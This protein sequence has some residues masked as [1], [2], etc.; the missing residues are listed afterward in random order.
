MAKL[1]IKGHPARGKEVI[2][3]LEMLGGVNVF[4]LDGT[5]NNYYYYIDENSN[6]IYH[7]L[8]INLEYGIVYTLEEFEEKFPYKVDDVVVNHK[9]GKG[10]IIRML[11]IDNE[12]VYEIHFEGCMAYCKANELC[13]YDAFKGL[14]LQELTEYLSHATREELD[15]TME[16]IEI[17][18]APFKVG[19]KVIVKGYEKMGE[20]EIICVFKTYDGDIKYKT[21]NHLDTHYFMGD[22]L[23]KVEKSNKEENMEK[24]LEPVYELGTG[25]I[26]Y[27][28]EK[29][30]GEKYIPIGETTLY[31]QDGY[32]F[33]DETNNI[34]N[35]KKIT[36]ARK[37]PQYPKN[38][39]ELIKPKFKDGDIISNGRF[40]AIFHK[41][42][43]GH[44]YYHCWY[45]L[46]YNEF[47][48]KIDCGIGFIEEYRYA[49]EE[50]K[51]RL[52]DA[53]KAS[54]Y[55]WNPKTKAMERS[56]EK[57]G[58]TLNEYQRKALRTNAKSSD[59]E[60]Y[61]LFGL[62]AEVGE[63]ADKIAKAV[64]KEIITI[65]GDFIYEGK[66]AT[67][68]GLS[69]LEYA[70]FENGLKAELGDVLWF[71]AHLA[72][73]FSWTLEEVGQDNIDKLTSRQKR[74]VIIGNGDNR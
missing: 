50:E 73:R 20:D 17:A 9:Y 35:A 13:K 31:I 49:T 1:A 23:M 26:L 44:I 43:E 37:Q 74:G 28:E 52:F 66:N 53:I 34:I 40:I 58:L 38:Y 32:E 3:L 54:G 41:F 11:W 24:R 71:V 6:K 51:Q 68:D 15:K 16:E 39:E 7:C 62:F 25:K 5:M 22:S 48:A 33:R 12:I 70:E 72:H 18:L 8:S 64:R 56:A 63:I 60:S 19:D 2:Q 14:L 57:D 29:G 45:N 61:S 27:Y 21:K 65:N 36:L 55:K 4:N 67:K 30:S 42:D 59:N 46:K 69:T 47:K 10:L